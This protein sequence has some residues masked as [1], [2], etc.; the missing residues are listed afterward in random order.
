MS[1]ARRGAAGGPAKPKRPAKPARSR[2]PKLD[3]GKAAARYAKGATLRSVARAAGS[4]AQQHNLKRVGY[5]I[6][7]RLRERG[8]VTDEFNRIGVSLRRVCE[9]VAR[10]LEATRTVTL[11]FQGARTEQWNEQD[12]A[13]QAEA[14]RQYALLTGLVTLKLEPASDEGPLSGLSDAAAARLADEIEALQRGQAAERD[15]GREA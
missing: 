3:Y 1:K 4:A 6:I 12:W 7:R 9:S 10:R 2:G 13:A 14:V 8:E 5:E 11:S 15:G